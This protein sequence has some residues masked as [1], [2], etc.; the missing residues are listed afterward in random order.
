MTTAQIFQLLGA[1]FFV[2]GLGMLA[3][4]KEAR[5]FFSEA[6]E[7]IGL[8]YYGGLMALVI[9][10][11]LLT[12][13][14][15]SLILFVIGWLALLKG[16]FLLLFPSLVARLGKII[17]KKKIC[18]AVSTWVIMLLGLLFLFIGYFS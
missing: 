17:A 13:G 15:Q 18:L 6:T 3:N 12:F 7:S 8:L 14:G 5:K 2:L 16:L 10:Y 11:L 9:G 1:T 4:P